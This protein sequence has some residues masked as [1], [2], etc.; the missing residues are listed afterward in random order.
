VKRLQHTFPNTPICVCIEPEQRYS[1][2]KCKKLVLPESGRGIGYAKKE[3]GKHA[4][5]NGYTSFIL[6]DDD[7]V[8]P[9]NLLQLAQNLE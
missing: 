2:I 6:L 9:D 8:V 4:S 3:C 7:S 5:A 1:S